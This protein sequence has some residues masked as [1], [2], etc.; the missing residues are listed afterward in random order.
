MIAVDEER[1]VRRIDDLIGLRDP[2]EELHQT[3]LKVRVQVKTRLIEQQN[4]IFVS[5]PAL[6]QEDQIEGQEPLKTLASFFEGHRK[7]TVTIGNLKNEVVAVDIEFEPVLI[8]CPQ[9][10]PVTGQRKRGGLHECPPLFQPT[11]QLLFRFVR[12]KRLAQGKNFLRV[13]ARPLEQR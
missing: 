7:R 9:R 11:K 10:H 6:D 2:I 4:C 12:A 5:L 1:Q 3:H 13:E 8:A